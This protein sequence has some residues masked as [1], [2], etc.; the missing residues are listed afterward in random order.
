MS[1]EKH[2]PE[3]ATKTPA[4]L[5]EKAA[6]EAKAGA[7]ERPHVVVFDN[8]TKQF[9][10][11]PNARVAIE[12]VTF[13]VED[14]AHE[15]QRET[16]VGE[17]PRVRGLVVL[18][19]VLAEFDHHGAGVVVVPQ[20]PHESRPVDLARHPGWPAVAEHQFAA[21]RDAATAPKPGFD[22]AGFFD[23]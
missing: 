20:D 7:S 15:L 3:S 21:R 11:G 22:R 18:G 14:L 5:K 19:L 8:V 16:G 4:E 23:R 6:T 17:E 13:T 9:G 10:E 1:D 12:N 2:S